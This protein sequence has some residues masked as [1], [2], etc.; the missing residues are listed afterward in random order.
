MIRGRGE[1]PR[2]PHRPP[3]AIEVNVPEAGDRTEVSHCR[4]RDSICSK[5]RS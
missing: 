1:H 5:S 2:D 3:S 4:G